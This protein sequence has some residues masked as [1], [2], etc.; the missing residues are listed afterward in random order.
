MRIAL[1]S[2]IHANLPA[3][4]AAL[5]P[6][7]HVQWQATQAADAQLPDAL[8]AAGLPL[9]VRAPHTPLQQQGCA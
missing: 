5:A 8:Q 6:D 1:V 2:D 3:L 7:W 4:K 9:Q